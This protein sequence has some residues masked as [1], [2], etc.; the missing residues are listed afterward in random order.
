MDFLGGGGTLVEAATAK[1]SGISGFGVGDFVDLT[2]VTAA[3]D[4]LRTGR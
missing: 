4:S 1:L 3:S 2:A